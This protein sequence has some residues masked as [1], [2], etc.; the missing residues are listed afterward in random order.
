MIEDQP[1]GRKEELFK[2]FG[3]E[4]DS[5]KGNTKMIVSVIA[6]IVVIG[7]F[8]FLIAALTG[9]DEPTTLAV[10]DLS[11]S[12]EELAATQ[13]NQ[14]ALQEIGIEPAIVSEEQ[15]TDNIDI[16]STNAD[17]GTANTITQTTIN[18][19][20]QAMNKIIELRK[21]SNE[22]D[23]IKTADIISDLS[24]YLEMLEDDTN[25]MNSWQ[26]IISCAYTVCDDYVYVDMIDVIATQDT[27]NTDHQTVHSLIETYNFWDGRNTVLF[28]ESLT[29]TNKMITKNYN[30]EIVSKWNEMIR[31]NGGCDNFNNLLFDMLGLVVR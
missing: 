24:L 20:L 2:G 25:L 17:E 21:Y 6:V 3:D 8:I 14:D 29:R 4:E 22:A 12:E 13:A 5:K 31:C 7:L 26:K 10:A 15:G 19:Y 18:N 9:T 30:T 1:E 16:L 28:S 23:L 11:G 27:R